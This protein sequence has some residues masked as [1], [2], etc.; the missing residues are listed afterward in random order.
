V[1]DIIFTCYSQPASLLFIILS[2]IQALVSSIGVL[3]PAC[4]ILKYR[5]NVQ[6]FLQTQPT[7]HSSVHLNYKET[8]KVH[9][10]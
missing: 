4:A 2:K 8:G 3:S 6:M 10:T 1:V 7:K 9:V 5:L